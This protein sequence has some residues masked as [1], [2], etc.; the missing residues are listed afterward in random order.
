[1]TDNDLV[2]E[3]HEVVRMW[4]ATVTV[5]EIRTYEVEVEVPATSRE[6][7]KARLEDEAIDEALNRGHEPSTD[8]ET[9]IDPDSIEE[10][11]EVDDE[12]EAW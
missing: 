8:V 12:D 11:E 9:E 5:R 10:G 1:M 6:E 3:V 7:A 2:A 4:R